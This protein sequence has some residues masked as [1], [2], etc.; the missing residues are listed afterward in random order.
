MRP[1]AEVTDPD[2]RR[3][4]GF[5]RMMIVTNPP[6]PWG[7]PGQGVLLYL[8]GRRGRPVLLPVAGH[9]PRVRQAVPPQ[10]IQGPGASL[11]GGARPA[12]GVP[13]RLAISGAA[14]PGVGGR[15]AVAG[16]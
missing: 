11:A 13:G 7:E 8:R 3:R 9:R 12:A 1:G 15:R 2:V 16:A 10:E 4:S 5:V 14:D 6:Q